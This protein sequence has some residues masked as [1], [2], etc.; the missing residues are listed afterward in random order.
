MHS[1]RRLHITSRGAPITGTLLGSFGAFLDFEFREYDYYVGVYD[2]VVLFAESICGV[3]FVRGEQTSDYDRCVD[4]FAGTA[5]DSL[6]IG[7]NPRA[8]YVFALVA[9]RDLEERGLMRFAYEPMPEADRSMSI[10]YQGLEATLEAGRPTPDP[11]TRSVSVEEEFFTTLRDEGFVPTPNADGSEPLLAQ[12][13]EDPE[14]WSAVLVRRAT[15]RLVHLEQEAQELYE[16]QEPD[17]EKR[18]KANPALMG[19]TAYALQSATYTYPGFT[20]APSVAPAAWGW[21]N[22][23]PYEV[24]FDFAGNDLVMT[25]RPT[26]SLGRGSNLGFPFGVGISRGLVSSDE[27][28]QDDSFFTLGLDYSR[29]M[30]GRGLSSWGVTPAWFHTFDAAA[31]ERRDSFGF[32]VRV[33]LLKNRLSIRAG[34][35]DVNDFGDTWFVLLGIADLPGAVYWLT[36]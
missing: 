5:Y 9:R 24:A 30:K 25:W 6:G 20:F 32:D 28:K 23:I 1:D 14:T 4:T 19:V 18:A 27:S 26:V 35:R 7:S 31:V 3:H 22:V 12:I 2:A 11:A 21:R 33:G 8:R 36:R 17:P 29:L 34:A 15:N 16:A 10:V 13:M